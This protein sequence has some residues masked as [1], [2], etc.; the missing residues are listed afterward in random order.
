MLCC[1]STDVQRVRFL[2]RSRRPYRPKRHGCAIG[3]DRRTPEP[4]ARRSRNRTSG[5]RASP[6]PPGTGS[7]RGGNTLIEHVGLLAEDA[8]ASVNRVIAGQ[9]TDWAA[10]A[11]LA[12]LIER[13]STSRFWTAPLRSG[14][15]SQR[16]HQWPPLDRSRSSR[17]ESRR[18]RSARSATCEHGGSRSAPICLRSV[19]FL[20]RQAE[21]RLRHGELRHGQLLLRIIDIQRRKRAQF[22]LLLR[23]LEEF[24]R[25]RR[26]RPR[27]LSGFRAPETT[28]Q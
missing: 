18:F 21:F 2:R 28:S 5:S 8:A 16:R 3:S 22:Q 13:S 15:F 7:D 17:W 4:V 23:Q 10:G 24:R 19:V 25:T 12:A 1:G 20:L 6:S 11:F 27:R 9:A 26:G 14:R